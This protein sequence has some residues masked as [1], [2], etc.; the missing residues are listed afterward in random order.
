M[1]TV[2]DVLEPIRAALAKRDEEIAELKRENRALK[3][4]RV[5]KLLDAHD[6][7]EHFG[8][9]R[10]AAYRVLNV[11]G[12]KINNRLRIFIDDVRPTLEE[13]H[14][15]NKMSESDKRRARSAERRRARVI[16]SSS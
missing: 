8:I 11:G 10:A 4:A 15:H 12:T 13:L 7:Q 1:T 5:P 2:S 14:L 9:S 16:S 3:A 6:L